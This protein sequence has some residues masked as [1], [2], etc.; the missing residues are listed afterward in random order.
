VSDGIRLSVIIAAYN[1]ER[2]IA[3]VVERV[4]EVPLSIEIVA[5]DDGS[6]DG[7]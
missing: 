5:V 7:T 4:R 1:E 6:T 3:A 2:T